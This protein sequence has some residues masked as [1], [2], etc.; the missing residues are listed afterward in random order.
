MIPAGCVERCPACP[1]RALP[2]A[3]SRSRKMEWLQR[4]LSEWGAAI[5]PLK[6]PAERWA[7][8][9]KTQLHARWL[10]GRWQ[11]GVIRF[12]GR[13]E[14]FISIPDCPLHAREINF[15]YAGAAAQAGAHLP[16]AFGIA[17]GS[18]FTLVMKCRRREEI[19]AEL[20]RWNW[21]AG[22]SLFVNWNPGAGKRAADSRQQEHLLGPAELSAGGLR[23]GPAAFRQQIPEMEE[24]ALDLAEVFLAASGATTCVDLYCGIGAGLARWQR[25]GWKAVGV[26]L[27]GE[28][29]ACA[30]I[31]SPAS[32]L[33]RGRVEDRLPQLG[34]FIGQQPFVVYTNPPR[35]GHGA[36]ALDWLMKSAPERIAYLSCHPRSLA[37]DLKVLSSRYC[38]EKIQPFDFFPQTAQ[39]ENLALLRRLA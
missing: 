31:N 9:R 4:E 24:G 22:F 20:S 25:R 34:E 29:L 37:G 7:Y 16:L 8:R 32:I 19:V 2:E 15:M 5:E 11:F 26:E 18:A 13:E 23:H 27:S 14:E 17:S 38:V 3:E 30:A 12:R 6:T 28:A 10:E 33:L 36:E 39:V 1:H 21:P 35:S